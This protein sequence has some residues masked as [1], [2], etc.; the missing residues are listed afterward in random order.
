MKDLSF[1]DV[2]LS[3]VVGEWAS[4]LKS[5]AKFMMKP[6]NELIP[7]ST[8]VAYTSAFKVALIKKYH[9]VGVPVQLKSEIWSRMLAKIRQ[10]KFEYA[11]SKA[12]CLFG[13]KTAATID[14]KRWIVALVIWK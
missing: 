13:L 11:H 9:T 8:T 5:F 4:Y 1:E 10:F 12:N 7:Y 6:E 2:S 3:T 14:D